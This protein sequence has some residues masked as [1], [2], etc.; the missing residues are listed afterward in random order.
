MLAVKPVKPVMAPAPFPTAQLV[1]LNVAQPPI[2]PLVLALEAMM[3]LPVKGVKLIVPPAVFASA[4]KSMV[5]VAVDVDA[6]L[7]PGLMFVVVN[8]WVLVPVRV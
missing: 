3:L 8:D 4:P 6:V 2:I 7:D 1:L 5:W